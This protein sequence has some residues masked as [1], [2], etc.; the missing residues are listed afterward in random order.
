MIDRGNMDVIAAHAMLLT[1]KG[2][3]GTPKGEC[4][5]RIEPGAPEALD[6]DSA[7]AAL[8]SL[9]KPVCCGISSVD[10]TPTI[11]WRHVSE[12][13]LQEPLVREFSLLGRAPKGR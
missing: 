1:L 7:I 8:A 11:S 3:L 13:D 2:S 5:F 6:W 4:R 9:P 12:T 10:G